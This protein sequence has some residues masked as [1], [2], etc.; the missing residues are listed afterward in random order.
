[1]GHNDGKNHVVRKAVL[2]GI[3]RVL[4]ANPLLLTII[5]VVVIGMIAYTLYSIDY[6]LKQIMVQYGQLSAKR[7]DSKAGFDKRLFYVKTDE[8]G[9]QII[10]VGSRSEE[11]AEQV[12]RELANIANSTGGTYV[13][14]TAEESEVKAALV[15][16]GYD[17]QKA[18]AMAR[19]Y[20]IINPVLGTNAAIGLMA[21]I[22]NEGSLGE[23]EHSFSLDHAYGFRL[24]SGGAI[25]KTIAD[26]EYARDW[27]SVTG[28]GE[29]KKGSCGVG[30]VQWSFG[31]RVACLN[32]AL[33]IMKSDND[34]TY[35]NW[36]VVEAVYMSEELKPGTTYYDSVSCHVGAD[37]VE[38]WAEAFNDYYEISSGCCSNGNKMSGIGNS[39]KKRRTEAT[40]IAD[41]LGGLN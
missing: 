15:A 24:P 11:E 26:I 22:A 13:S 17:N 8:N 35:E 41:I 38:N 21:N 1:M 3:M 28:S 39:C 36:L 18:I 37:T 9:N 2:K 27:D 40:K 12:K 33:S 31:R 16:G 32:V 14:L 6:Q 25:M 10:T 30:S 34:V 7:T 5:L 20:G 29:P 23:V 4:L 19:A